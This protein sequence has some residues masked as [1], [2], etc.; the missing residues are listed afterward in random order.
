[1][2]GRYVY[3]AAGQKVW[4]DDGGL[5]DLG[6]SQSGNPAAGGGGLSLGSGTAAG[7]RNKG[8]LPDYF[9]NKEAARLLWND[10]ANQNQIKA[11]QAD[12]VAMNR[13]AEMAAR[14]KQYEMLGAYNTMAGGG[15][16]S[17]AGA[18]TREGMDATARAMMG[19]GGGLRA[20][21]AG[22]SA[23]GSDTAFKG[24]AAKAGEQQNAW[25][26]LTAGA[27]GVR[28]ADL[29]GNT[30]EA[31]L[32]QQIALANAGFRQ[33]A[34]TAN[35]DAQLAALANRAATAD[36]YGRLAGANRS[37]HTQS[38]GMNLDEGRQQ[39]ALNQAHQDRSD[40]QTA[41]YLKTAASFAA[42]ASD[43]RVKHKIKEADLSSLYDKLAPYE[44]EY[45]DTSIEGTS[46]GKH[47]SVMAQDLEKSEIGKR[48]VFDSEEGHK[49]VDYAKLLPAQVA[50]TAWLAKRVAKLEKGTKHDGK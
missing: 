15:G 47:V 33:Q 50:A 5:E 16:P 22:G 38:W 29:A 25:S 23:M 13:A 8:G 14:A 19:S 4:T 31:K 20:G 44:Y 18:M 48:A 9:A 7:D 41:N 1:M 37:A 46:P 21:L 17:V 24:A 36:L 2:A 35:Q 12:P 40:A 45:K 11:S 27:G 42:M 30:E 49:M 32:A 34:G 43:E 28:A 6:A 3:N 39:K 26:M 10:S